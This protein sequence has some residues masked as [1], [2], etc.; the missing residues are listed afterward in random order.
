MYAHASNTCIFGQKPE[1]RSLETFP[2]FE[3]HKEIKRVFIKDG[4][5]LFRRSFH[6]LLTS[7]V[8]CGSE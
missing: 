2:F 6:E 1:K 4:P 7:A 8:T 5:M 3:N